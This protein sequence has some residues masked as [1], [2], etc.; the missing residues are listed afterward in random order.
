MLYGAVNQHAA[1]WQ[2][3]ALRLSIKT[4]FIRRQ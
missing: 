1:E 3:A 2:T 4:Q